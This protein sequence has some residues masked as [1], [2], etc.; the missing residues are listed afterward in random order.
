MMNN[1]ERLEYFKE[2]CRKHGLKITMQRLIIYQALADDRSHPCADD[3]YQRIHREYPNISY[4]TLNRTLLTFSRIGLIKTISHH[5]PKRRFDTV[6]A[7][8]HHLCCIRCHKIIDFESEELDQ[9]T[10]PDRIKDKY[11][12]LGK[13]VVIECICDECM[14]K[15]KKGGK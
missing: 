6:I 10:V 3:I 4:D 12:I 13:K 7:D 11:T 8:H 9:I 2:Q 15:D 1:N 5:G 14:K